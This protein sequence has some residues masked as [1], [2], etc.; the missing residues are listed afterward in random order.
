MAYCRRD[1]GKGVGEET[2]MDFSVLQNLT[3]LVV[4]FKWI[5]PAVG[6]VVLAFLGLSAL[7]RIVSK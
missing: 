6:T 4:H 1:D 7:N 2:G 5:V 3:G